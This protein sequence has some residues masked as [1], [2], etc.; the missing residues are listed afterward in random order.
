[1]R[2]DQAFLEPVSV[3]IEAIFNNSTQFNRNLFRT[4]FDALLQCKSSIVLPADLIVSVCQSSGL[5]TLGVLLLEEYLTSSNSSSLDPQ[6][7]T[8]EISLW[9]S[10]A[11]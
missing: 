1:M 11:E 10:L 6:E 5:R 7:T 9:I 2:S 3:A 8:N 4:L